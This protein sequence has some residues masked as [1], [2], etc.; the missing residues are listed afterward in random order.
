M[1]IKL[2]LS[3]LS[4]QN[5]VDCLRGRPFAVVLVRWSAHTNH[6]AGLS[7]SKTLV[8]FSLQ[9]SQSKQSSGSSPGHNNKIKGQESKTCSISGA[10]TPSPPAH[11]RCSRAHV[12]T[13][14]FGRPWFAL[15][16]GRGPRGGSDTQARRLD[17][18]IGNRI[19]LILCHHVALTTSGRKAKSQREGLLHLFGPATLHV[20]VITPGRTNCQLS[21]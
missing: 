9:V 3:F 6:E 18:S 5:T 14:L 21:I 11:T 2:F 15:A 7:L 4:I 8:F 13:C 1:Q 12:L 10:I 19:V 16:V 17:S 20:L